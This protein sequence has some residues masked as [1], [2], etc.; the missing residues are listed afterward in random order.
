MSDV[1]YTL[2]LLLL[3]GIAIIIYL[4]LFVLCINLVRISRW[5]IKEHAIPALLFKKN[6]KI[7]IP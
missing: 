3:G 4:L 5:Y 7:L 2:R 1:L 6:K